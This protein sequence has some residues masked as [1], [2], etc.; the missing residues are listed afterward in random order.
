MKPRLVIFRS[1]KY[2]YAQITLSGKTVVS[3]EKMIDPIEAGK[4]L[5]EKAIKSKITTVSFDRNGYKYHGNVKKLA[6]AAREAGLKF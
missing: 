3:V 5:A 1:N 4:N 6:E 2:L